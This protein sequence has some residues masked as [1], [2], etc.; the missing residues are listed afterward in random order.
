[1]KRRFILLDR[2]G[3]INQD[4][5]GYIRTPQEWQPLPGSLQALKDLTEAGYEIYVITNQSGIGRGYYSLQ[6]MHAIHRKMHQLVRDAGGVI[7]GIYYC[8]HAPEEK[9]GC[10]KPAS[11]LF[12]QCAKEHRLDLTQAWFVG[13]KLS[14]LRGGEAVGMRSALV[15]TGYGAQTLSTLPQSHEYPVFADLSAFCSELL[16]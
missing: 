5:V 2:D 9:C 15:K 1:M 16:N 4:S 6:D 11:A 12:L 8:P 14:D 13:D 10:R 3:V 7:R